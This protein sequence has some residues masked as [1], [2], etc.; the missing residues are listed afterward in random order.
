MITEVL[1]TLVL[2]N[3]SWIV[4]KCFFYSING[5]F[6]VI[7]MRKVIINHQS[8]VSKPSRSIVFSRGIC[9]CNQRWPDCLRRFSDRRN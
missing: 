6:D 4:L 2:S 3:L 9:C 5:L 1:V 8:Y 7:S